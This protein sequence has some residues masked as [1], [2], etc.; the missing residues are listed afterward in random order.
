[1]WYILAALSVLTVA[2][3]VYMLRRAGGGRFPW[4]Q[5]YTKG[6]E[7]GFNF[8]ELNLLRRMAVENQLSNPSSLFWSIR[9]LDRSIKGVILKLRSEGR[10]DDIHESEL[11]SKLFD[12]RKKVEFDQPR[13]KLGIKSSRKLP[14]RQTLT[15]TLPGVGTYRSQI[16]ENLRRYMAISYPEGPA[17]P[18]DFV[19]K[20]QKIN[21]HLWRS[22]DAGYDFETKV[23]DDFK[24][25]DY[26]ILHMAHSDALVRTQQRRSIREDV[27]KAAKLFPLSNTNSGNVDIESGPGLKC[28]MLDISEDGAAVLVGGKAK[29]GLTVKVQ[30]VLS[31]EPI[32]I[33]GVV[34]Q[35]TFRQSKNQ[36]ILHIQAD[37]VSTRNKN[38][39]LSYVYNIFGERVADTG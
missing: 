28:R 7:S 13:Y 35:I 39:I 4:I 23:I 15:L 37:T 3:T 5:F 24:E 21:I 36:S 19:W 26:S 27:N 30:V 14:T 9:Q 18:P 6:K 32:V 38:R 12:Y 29:A 31:D 20:A 1:M 10:E 25:R 22:G 2:A 17:L 11:V 16:V 8:G 34:R 33:V